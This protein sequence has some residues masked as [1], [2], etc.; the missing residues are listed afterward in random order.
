[1]VERRQY[2]TGNGEGKKG[3][4]MHR[5]TIMQEPN[6]NMRTYTVRARVSSSLYVEEF[7]IPFQRPKRTWELVGQTAQR[8]LSSLEERTSDCIS[9]IWLDQRE[10][11]EC[12]V[13]VEKTAS[14]SWSEVEPYVLEA[15]RRKLL[16]DEALEV[17]RREKVLL[18]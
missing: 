18:I 17:E 13:S 14:S 8:F 3:G 2:P 10:D 16:D 15:I 4:V 5:I 12:K 11:D 7:Q 6:P 1:M 9:R